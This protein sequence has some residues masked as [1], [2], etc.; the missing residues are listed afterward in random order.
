MSEQGRLKKSPVEVEVM[1][2]AARATEAGMQAG[3]DA[4]RPGVTE[5]GRCPRIETITDL[6]ALLAALVDD[7]L[8]DDFDDQYNGFVNTDFLDYS[9]D[10]QLN[11]IP[12]L[13]RELYATF[14]AWIITQ[15]FNPF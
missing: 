7:G 11:P 2:K 13:C 12:F 14:S 9:V 8:V 5:D 4:C 15:R 1:R 10:S 6:T 3:I